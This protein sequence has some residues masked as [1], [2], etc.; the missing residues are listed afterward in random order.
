MVCYMARNVCKVKLKRVNYSDR[1]P[2][3]GMERCARGSPGM[4]SDPG[5]FLAKPLPWIICKKVII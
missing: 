2:V 4:L 3:S 5:I 1:T